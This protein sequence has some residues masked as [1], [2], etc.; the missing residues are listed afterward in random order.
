MRN[1]VTTQTVTFSNENKLFYIESSYKNVNFIDAW[2][3]FAFQKIYL[4]KFAAENFIEFF[5]QRGCYFKASRNVV[6]RHTLQ[7]SK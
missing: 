2:N 3:V 7:E 6:K 4:K 1:I 5:L